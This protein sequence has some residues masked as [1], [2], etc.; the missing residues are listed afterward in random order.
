MAADDFDIHV[1]FSIA[2]PTFGKVN[3]IGLSYITYL[4]L[5]HF[6]LYTSSCIL[7]FYIVFNK[8]KMNKIKMNKKNYIKRTKHEAN[9]HS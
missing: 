5:I 8:K 7:I 3:L 9:K 2:S 1:I 4:Y 6:I